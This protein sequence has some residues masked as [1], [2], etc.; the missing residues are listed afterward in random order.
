MKHNRAFWLTVAALFLVSLACNAFA[1]EVEPALPPPPT[2]AVGLGTAVPLPGED[3]QETGLAP[4][5]TLPSTGEVTP[6]PDVPTLL[7]LTDVNIRTGPGVAFSAVT[8]LRKDETAKVLGKDL[9]SGWWLIECPARVTTTT[10]CWISGRADFTAVNLPDAVPV[11]EPPPT[12]TPTPRPLGPILAYVDNGR[13]QI[14]TLNIGQ[15]PV[16]IGNP[17]LLVENPDILDLRIAPDGKRIAFRVRNGLSNDLYVTNVDGSGSQLL[18]SAAE[19]PVSGSQAAGFAVWINQ[20]VWQNSQTLL[21]NTE[22]RNSAAPGTNQE[23]LWQVTL[24]GEPGQRFPPGAGAGFI[25]VSPSGQI[26]MSRSNAILRVTGSASSEPLIQFTPTSTSS[27]SRH[28]PQP[29][30]TTDSTRALVAIPA[31]DAPGGRANLWQIPASGQAFSLGSLD[32]YALSHPILWSPDGN[33]LAYVRQSAGE[34][35]LLLLAGTGGQDLSPEHSGGLLTFWGWAPDSTRFLY[36]APGFFAL[37]QV[38]Q[39]ALASTL[40]AGIQVGGVRW[41]SAETFMLAIGSSGGWTL[42]SAVV[43]GRS[44]PLLVIGG[45]QPEF[46]VWLP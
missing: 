38:G 1:G 26:L 36:A 25:A 13:L 33:R 21:F 14:H 22:L 31:A 41:I 24:A 18:V 8:V 42:T 16:T 20:V 2:L 17:V 27:G 15:T 7:A 9:D 6:T 29:Q 12:P 44:A 40:P 30:W 39:N 10:A 32:G 4:T 34:L 45:A 11:A 37:G 35:P 28:Y 23:D 19:L 43:D 46:A 5:A 3:G